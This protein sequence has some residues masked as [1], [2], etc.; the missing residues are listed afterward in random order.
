MSV[1]MFSLEL[2][3]SVGLNVMLLAMS[4][5]LLGFWAGMFGFY[6]GHNSLGM[7]SRSQI[8]RKLDRPYA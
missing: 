8:S 5:G 1:F 3:P 4:V 2:M 6:V 7:N